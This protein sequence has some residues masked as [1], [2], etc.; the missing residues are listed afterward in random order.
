MGGNVP[1]SQQASL[2]AQSARLS[3]SNNLIGA[4]DSDLFVSLKQHL[5]HWHTLETVNALMAD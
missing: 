3:T 2:S 1:V 5:Y 4:L